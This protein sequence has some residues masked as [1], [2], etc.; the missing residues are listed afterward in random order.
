MKTALFQMYLI[1][2]PEA[3]LIADGT[4]AVDPKV[5]PKIIVGPFQV[6]AQNV[7][8]AMTKAMQLHAADVQDIDPNRLQVVG[9]PMSEIN[10]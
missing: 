7:T 10:Y 3:T 5:D 1:E 6:F 4:F 8:I 9:V 2:K